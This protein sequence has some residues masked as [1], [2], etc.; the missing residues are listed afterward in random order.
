MDQP[1]GTPQDPFDLIVAGMSDALSQPTETIPSVRCM[2]R[3]ALVS[4]IGEL[5]NRL[6]GPTGH[7][8]SATQVINRLTRERILQQVPFDD[9][10]PRVKQKRLLAVG[11][12]TDIQTI[13]PLE[14]LQAHV[15]T[16]IVCYMTALEVHGL[17]TQPAMHHHIARIE[18]APARLRASAETASTRAAARTVDHSTKTAIPPLGQWQFTYQGLRY[19]M[20]SREPR[21]L[22]YHQL[23]HLSDKSRY[24]VTTLEQ[25]LVDTLHRPTS[26]GGPAVV[27]EAW[28]SAAE[29]L[30]PEKMTTLLRQIGD[31]RLLRRAGYMLGRGGLNREVLEELEVLGAPTGED[32]PALSLLPGIPYSTLDPRWRVL[33]P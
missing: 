24:R 3:S 18:T 33:V 30:N 28:E 22:R 20:T 15:P 25:T 21:F 12:G 7:V 16:G 5:A 4:L 23:R 10:S 29:V 9:L 26:C 32:E 11:L 13:H 31:L 17:T 19:Y 14:L 8:P 6:T 1:A 2:S 27:F